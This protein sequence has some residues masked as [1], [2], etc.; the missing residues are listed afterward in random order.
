[1]KYLIRWMVLCYVFLTSCTQNVPTSQPIPTQVN[2]PEL[3]IDQAET[4]ASVWD[5]AVTPD[6]KTLIAILE[7]KKVQLWDVETGDFIKNIHYQFGKDRMGK[8]SVGTLSPDGKVLAVGGFE[9]DVNYGVIWLYHLER[10]A[11][12]GILRGHTSQVRALAFSPDG[13]RLASGGYDNMIKIW[14]IS[15]KENFDQPVPFSQPVSP[16]SDHIPKPQLKV[17]PIVPEII[18]TGHRGPIFDIAF[19]PNGNKLVSASY[20]E[21]LRLWTLFRTDQPTVNVSVPAPLSDMENPGIFMRLQA[22]A[23][24]YIQSQ[25][26]PRF[27]DAGLFRYF[28]VIM[29]HFTPTHC[30]AYSP[31]GHYIVSGGRDRKLVLWDNAGTFITTL[32]TLQQ[33]VNAIVFSA[34]SSKLAAIT[35]PYN[36]V[37]AIPSGNKLSSFRK[38]TD[39]G[40]AAAFFRNKWVASAGMEDNDIYLW[41]ALSGEVKTHIRNKKHAVWTVAFGKD[42]QLA[43]G[44]SNLAPAHFRN[45]ASSPRQYAEYAEYFPLEKSFDFLNMALLLETPSETEFRRVQTTYTENSAN[46]ADNIGLENSDQRLSPVTKI[47]EK[48]LSLK[49]QVKS[50][51]ELPEET[52]TQ[53]EQNITGKEEGIHK[54]D[55]Q[56]EREIS[57]QKGQTPP[58]QSPEETLPP[59]LKSGRA[60]NLGQKT[61]EKLSKEVTEGDS[62]AKNEQSTDASAVVKKPIINVRTITNGQ[63]L[64]GYI[65]SYT[66]TNNG[67]IVVGSSRTLKLYHNDGTLIREFV[68]HTGEVIAVSVSED[69][70]LLASFSGSTITLWN[71]STGEYLANLFVRTDNE[72]ICWTPQGYYTTSAQGEEYVNWKLTQEAD[73]TEKYYPAEAFRTQFRQPELV[74]RTITLGSFEQAFV[75]IAGTTEFTSNP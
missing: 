48:I 19:S 40:V 47:L 30:V 70:R 6:G 61:E 38:H 12:I 57:S 64:D 50:K 41:D 13:K 17:L 7:N 39:I 21:T 22:W 14:D 56:N 46:N 2:S 36:I 37:Y 15:N 63:R 4:S 44:Q 74:K 65:C 59:E 8:F 71:L 1:M 24:R 34:D 26:V 68:G 55:T 42:F 51:Q 73:G 9:K 58:K 20:D 43:F 5:V 31:D 27:L 52:E 29:E 16:K 49:L 45:H 10:Q 53:A 11:I 66:F 25:I 33:S 28:P 62:R 23:S 69:N 67:A 75:E 35:G 18:L 72:W 3:V 32:D 60:K 54:E